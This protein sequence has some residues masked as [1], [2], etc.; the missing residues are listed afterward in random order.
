MSDIAIEVI[1]PNRNI[2]I[3]KETHNI[4]VELPNRNIEVIL[5]SWDEQKRNSNSN[6]LC[7]LVA[8]ME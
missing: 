8:E 1:I 5:E 2:E 7:T 4:D 3:I 6:C